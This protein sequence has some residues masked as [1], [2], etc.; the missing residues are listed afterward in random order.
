VYGDD[1]SRLPDDSALFCGLAPGVLV[2]SGHSVGGNDTHWAACPGRPSD[3]EIGPTPG[4]WDGA[5]RLQVGTE[6]VALCH[7]PIIAR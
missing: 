4:H 3:R 5:A 6:D 1:I 2:A 7:G